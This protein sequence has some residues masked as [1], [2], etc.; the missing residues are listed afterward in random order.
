[1]KLTDKELLELYRQ[2]LTNKI[3]DRLGVTQASVQYRLQKSGLQN[4]YCAEDTVDQRLVKILHRTGL[5]SIGIALLLQTSV[6][7]FSQYLEELKQG[8]LLQ[9]Q[10]NCGQGIA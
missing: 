2:G 1:M 8:Q 6:P 10:D 3:A 9:T 7:V 4:D 5:T